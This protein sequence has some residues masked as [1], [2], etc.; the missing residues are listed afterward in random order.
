MAMVVPSVD[1]QLQRDVA[2]DPFDALDEYRD[3]DPFW[4]QSGD[5]FEGGFW[6]VTKFEQCRDVLQD[7]IAF[8]SEAWGPA[9]LLPTM[10]APPQLQKLR[11]LVM[12]HLTSEMDDDA[13]AIALAGFAKMVMMLRSGDDDDGEVQV[14]IVVPT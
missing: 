6:V 14:A 8:P 11:A 10:A 2:V 4:A 12:K 7:A 13:C 3:R 5:F 9:P 1:L